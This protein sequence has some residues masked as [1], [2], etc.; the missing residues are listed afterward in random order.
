MSFAA[1]KAE[2]RA[3]KR[4]RGPDHGFPPC[5]AGVDECLGGRTCRSLNRANTIDCSSKVGLF[6]VPRGA[7]IAFFRG[8]GTLGHAMIS[9]G[10][11]WAAGCNNGC[12]GGTCTNVWERLNLSDMYP[13]EGATHHYQCRYG[14]P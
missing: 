9:L 8:D 11:G 13:F 6:M 3:R 7:V 1:F 5:L 10:A 4:K 12:V 2:H 14:S